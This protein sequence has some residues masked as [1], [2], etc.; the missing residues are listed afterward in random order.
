MAIVEKEEWGKLHLAEFD[1]WTL[2]VGGNQHVLGWLIIFS[3]SAFEGSMAYP[4]F[5]SFSKQ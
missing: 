1:D 5:V 3:P 4:L 2:G